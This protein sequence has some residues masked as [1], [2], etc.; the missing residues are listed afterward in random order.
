MKRAGNLKNVWDVKLLPL[1]RWDLCSSGLLCSICWCLFSHISAQSIGLT[2]MDCLI[3]E[4]G[5]DKLSWK[6][7]KQL[8]TYAALQPRRAKTWPKVFSGNISLKKSI[9]SFCNIFLKKQNERMWTGCIWLIM[10]TDGLFWIWQ[11]S[12]TCH[13]MYGI[14]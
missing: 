1:C 13:K 5:T 4:D 14:D 6:V 8:P 10:K 7:D 9:H 11:Q 3:F 12:S 2:Y